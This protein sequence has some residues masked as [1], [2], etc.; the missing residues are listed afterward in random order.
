MHDVYLQLKSGIVLQENQVNELHALSNQ[1]VKF[2]ILYNIMNLFGI[3]CFV[4]VLFGLVD[5]VVNKLK[6]GSMRDVFFASLLT[7]F[8]ST[9]SYV[10]KLIETVGKQNI[11]S[12]G[13]FLSEPTLI[14]IVGIIVSSFSFFTFYMFS[15][16]KEKYTQVIALVITILDL[17]YIHW[18]IERTGWVNADH[19][20]YL[21]DY[22][23][24][25]LVAILLA[26][27]A[28]ALRFIAQ[29][30]TKK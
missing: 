16:I 25:C 13:Y 27:L 14:M 10:H 15:V 30:F 3:A 12:D 1:F 19:K 28:I 22:T 29:Q 2:E 11:A 8:G 18:L 26:P 9:L 6:I 7:I 20:Y 21:S 4:Y 23:L 24:V 5:L 17:A